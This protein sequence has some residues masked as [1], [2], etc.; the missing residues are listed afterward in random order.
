LHRD[1]FSGAG[2]PLYS[3]TL[4]RSKVGWPS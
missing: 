3:R 2:V 4:H 1:Y